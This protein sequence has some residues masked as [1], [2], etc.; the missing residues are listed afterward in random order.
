MFKKAVV[1][2]DDHTV[3][4]SHAAVINEKPTLLNYVAAIFA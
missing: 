1:D 2:Q 3:S 4:D